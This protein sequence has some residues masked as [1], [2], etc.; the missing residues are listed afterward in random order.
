M[1]LK[2]VGVISNQLF[3]DLNFLN[4]LIFKFNNNLKKIYSEFFR[5]FIANLKF[6]NYYIE[7]L[8]DNEE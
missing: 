3:V 5:E 1:I 6:I 7:N 4:F 8:S 2:K